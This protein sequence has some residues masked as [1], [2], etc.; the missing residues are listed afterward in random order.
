[1]LETTEK[2]KHIWKTSMDTTQYRITFLVKK[3]DKSGERAF[4]LCGY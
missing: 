3:N 2:W 4:I 1:M